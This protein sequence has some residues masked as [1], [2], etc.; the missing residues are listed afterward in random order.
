VSLNKD[1]LL[2]VL[3]MLLVFTGQAVAFAVSS[4]QMDTDSSATMELSMMD[5][6]GHSMMDTVSDTATPM[7]MDCCDQDCN[8]LGSC[9]SLMM[10]TSAYTFSSAVITPLDSSPVTVLLNSQSPSSLYRPPIIS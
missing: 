3:L 7:T 5:H 1:K 6:S 2:M 10:T 8:F 4:C 9:G